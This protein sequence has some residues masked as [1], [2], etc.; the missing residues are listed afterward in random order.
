MD[1][2]H[3][4]THFLREVCGRDGR[5]VPAIPPEVAQKLLNYPWPGNVRE[6]ENCME[7]L[8][9]LSS[10]Q[11]L[12][13]SDLPEAV[14]LH[15]RE[16]FTVQLDAAEEVVTLDQLEKRYVLRVLQLVKDNRSRAAVMLGIDRRTLYR[17][18]EGWGLPTERRATTA[19]A[20]PTAVA[21]S[22]PRG[23]AL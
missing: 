9:A 13:V 20:A 8:S 5:Q 12:S 18:L 7:R 11:S 10:T 19:P 16:R 1:V 23:A 4:A 22:G 6:L 21:P 15:E 17:R 14:R 2:V 3:L